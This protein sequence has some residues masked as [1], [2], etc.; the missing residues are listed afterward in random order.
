MEKCEIC[1][2][3]I[4]VPKTALKLCDDCFNKK[5][6]CGHKRAIHA[7]N[8]GTCI[9]EYSLHH[10]TKRGEFCPCEEFAQ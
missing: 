1:G 6:K 3:G 2:K 5:C 9:Y 10:K 8:Y 4:K 7:D